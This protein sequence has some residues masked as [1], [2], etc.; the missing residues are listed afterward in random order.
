MTVLAEH[1]HLAVVQLGHKVG[2]T[3]G[4]EWRALERDEWLWL[5]HAG[6]PAAV[7]RLTDADPPTDIEAVRR[8]GDHA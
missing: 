5:V 7:Q 6:A 3:V 1:R 8:M 4:G 2:L